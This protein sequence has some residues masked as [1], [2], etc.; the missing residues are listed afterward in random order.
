MM[1]D[2]LV[3]LSG[4]SQGVVR[5]AAGE[6]GEWLVQST[7]ADVDVSC[8]AEDALRPGVVYA[9][10]RE[11]GIFRSEDGGVEW[12]AIGME[13]HIVKS[14]AVSPHDSRVIFAGTKPALIFRSEDGG[15]NWHELE[16]FRRIPNRWWWFSPAD[17]RDYR[18]YVM[19]ISVSPTEPDVLIA[20]V[21]LGAVVRS[22]DGGETWSRHLSGTLRDCHSLKFHSKDGNWAYEAGGTG[23][24][25]AYSQDGGRTW[26][27]AKK[28]LEK[29]YGIV[30]AA[31][32][33]KPEV[34]YVAVAPS[35]FNA[36]G[37]DPEIYLYRWD[38]G[39]GWTRI[40]WGEHPL[41]ETPTALAV[42]GRESG[43]L[44]AGLK[45]GE[46]WRSP[47]Y[48]ENWDRL[49]FDLG[50]VWGAMLVLEGEG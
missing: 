8:L 13:G 48:G 38:G 29:S 11:Q 3:F 14:L 36:F 32:G 19:Q 20:G 43:H 6:E 35:P 47:D 18:A 10:S 9:G 15:R 16:G 31:D 1:T 5:A 44:Y 40:G 33:L 17:G 7:L 34:W 21:E 37:E 26:V 41:K 27:K 24:G 4:F 45:N 49:R 23:G 30:C 39:A 28:G 50:G 22:E 42:S 12:K 2:R 46:V 25:A